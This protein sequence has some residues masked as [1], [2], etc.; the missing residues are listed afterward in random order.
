M[1]NLILY[2]LHVVMDIESED[3]VDSLNFL[4]N[5][6]DIGHYYPTT[7]RYFGIKYTVHGSTMGIHPTDNDQ[8]YVNECIYDLG[9]LAALY[10]CDHL[11]ANGTTYLVRPL[12]NDGNL[13]W[14]YIGGVPTVVHTSSDDTNVYKIVN[15]VDVVEVGLNEVKRKLR[16]SLDSG[17]SC[18]IPA[19]LLWLDGSKFVP[20]NIHSIRNPEVLE[21]FNV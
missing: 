7:T 4:L 11:V 15:N 5:S 18:Y 10:S 3:R 9:K 16:R 6:D 13:K 1:T 8:D 2:N 20:L 12:W 14:K 21:K 19:D 17:L